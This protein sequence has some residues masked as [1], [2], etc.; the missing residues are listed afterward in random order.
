MKLRNT[1]LVVEKGNVLTARLEQSLR[2]KGYFS[3]RIEKPDSFV[4]LLDSGDLIR[5]LLFRDGD[6]GTSEENYTKLKILKSMSRDMPLLFCTANNSP[7]KEDRVRDLGLFY[8]H[9]E[10]MGLDPLVAAIDCAVKKS[11]IED[12]F[13]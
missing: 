6:Y 1:I 5:A 8:Y 13:L 7:Q 4:P 9:T 3:I 10:D 2:D 11:V 12:R